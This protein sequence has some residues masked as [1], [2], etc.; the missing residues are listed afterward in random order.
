MTNNRLNFGLDGTTDADFVQTINDTNTVDGRLVIYR[1]N[2]DNIT[3]NASSN[4]GTVYVI[5]GTN[6]TVD[7]FIPEQK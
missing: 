5:N 3:I 7:G 4:A 1:Q 2:V 6:V